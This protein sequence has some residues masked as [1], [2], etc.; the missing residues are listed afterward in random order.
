MQR[1]LGRTMWMAAA[2]CG[3]AASPAPARQRVVVLTD[4]ENEP[5]DTQSMVR[6]LAYAN[7]WDV[8]A[9]VATTPTHQKDKTA[10]WKI[11]ETVEAYGK[12]RENLARHEPGF[13]ETARLLAAIREGR[14]AFGMAAVGEG[15]VAKP[16]TMHIVLAVTDPGTP[17]LTR[18]RRVIVAVVPR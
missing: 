16:E 5:D 17:P 11:R 14:P 7:H 3:W 9:L 2:L 10:A 8:E 1:R 12:V 15:K 18:Y 13:P 6:F 4:I